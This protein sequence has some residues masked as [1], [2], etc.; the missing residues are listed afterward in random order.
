MT[1]ASGEVDAMLGATYS[2]PFSNPVPPTV[3]QAATMFACEA[4]VGRR[5]VDNEPN[6]FSERANTYR[7]LLSQIAQNRGGLDAATPS[8]ISAGYVQTSPILVNSSTA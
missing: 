2:T 7:K 4:L 6:R 8:A 1:T 5:L 3:I